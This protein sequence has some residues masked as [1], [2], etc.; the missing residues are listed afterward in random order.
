MFFRHMKVLALVAALCG[1]SVLSAAA[2][3]WSAG[4]FAQAG[5]I[6][7]TA[8]LVQATPNATMDAIS[9]YLQTNGASYSGDGFSLIGTTSLSDVTS[10][11]NVFVDYA[12]SL[13][14][15]TKYFTLIL[16]DG[17]FILSDLKE[18]TLISGPNGDSLTIAFAAMGSNKATWVTGKLGT[19]EVPEPTALALL[20]LGVAGLA[21]RRRA[22]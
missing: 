9:G 2:V 15:G 7:G 18:G 13:V 14:S 4:G 8:Y 16:V 6:T 1:S 17:T 3:T 21:L 5:A 19:G 22:A 20:A 11:S 12:G 10:F